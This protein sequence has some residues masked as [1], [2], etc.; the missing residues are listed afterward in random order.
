MEVETLN[1]KFGFNSGLG[2][3][4]GQS[5]PSE[6]STMFQ[7]SD[8]TDTLVPFAATKVPMYKTVDAPTTQGQAV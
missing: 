3:G 5:S 8:Y 2:L 7:Q 1:A 6:N 4:I